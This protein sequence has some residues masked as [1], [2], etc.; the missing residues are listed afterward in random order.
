MRIDELDD[1]EK[2]TIKT[3][4][5]FFAECM[6]A[7]DERRGPKFLPFQCVDES[8]G[9]LTNGEIEGLIERIETTR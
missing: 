4:L 1:L 9:C 6:A 7:D 8:I 5:T 3:A 2:A